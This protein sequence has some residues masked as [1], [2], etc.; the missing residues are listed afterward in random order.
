MMK[1]VLFAAVIALS[2]TSVLAQDVPVPGV[3]T[4]SPGGYANPLKLDTDRHKNENGE[5]KSSRAPAPFGRCNWEPL[6]EQASTELAAIYWQAAKAKDHH[7][8]Y[9]QLETHCGATNAMQLQRRYR[10]AGDLSG[11]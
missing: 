8:G 3:T 10:R 9:K 4:A 1:L 7:R 11:N 2:A 6:S 5:A